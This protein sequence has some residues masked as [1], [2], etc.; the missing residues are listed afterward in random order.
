MASGVFIVAARILPAQGLRI[1]LSKH[2]HRVAGFFLLKSKDQQHMLGN[3]LSRNESDVS[4]L[5]MLTATFK[6]QQIACLA[7]E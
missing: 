6:A 7:P 2:R 4:D 5:V 1:T 3:E